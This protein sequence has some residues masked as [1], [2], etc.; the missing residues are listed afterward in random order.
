MVAAGY[1][2]ARLATMSRT[3]HAT[4]MGAIQAIFTVW[5]FFAVPSDEPLWFWMT[6]IAMMIPAAWIGGALATRVVS[7]LA[8]SQ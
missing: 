6:G 4:V 3:A 7:A 8:P 1:V 2:T 5:A